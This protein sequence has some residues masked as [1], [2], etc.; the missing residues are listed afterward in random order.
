MLGAVKLLGLIL[1][2]AIPVVELWVFVQAA[3]AWGF[4]WALFAV[5]AI[6]VVGLWLVKVAGFSAMRRGTEAV[7]AGRP[8]TKELLDGAILLLAGT[9]LL[10]PGFV[11][12]ILGLLL[13]L[14]PVRALVRPLLLGWWARGRRAGRVQVINATYRGPEPDP[15][16]PAQGELLPPDDRW[17]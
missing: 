1:L 5:I 10:F 11:T 3:D 7:Q 8:P 16:A 6:S 15:A 2:I 4:W 14:P 12:G 9:L 17:A 13:L